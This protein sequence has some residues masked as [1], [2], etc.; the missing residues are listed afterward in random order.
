MWFLGNIFAAGWEGKCAVIREFRMGG[1]SRDKERRR[2]KCFI[3]ELGVYVVA[4]FMIVDEV[5]R[6]FKV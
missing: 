2:M 6:S 5:F 4:N 1:I 3:F